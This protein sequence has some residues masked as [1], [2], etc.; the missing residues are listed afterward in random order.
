MAKLK[1]GPMATQ[2]SGSIGSTTFSHNRGG[3]YMRNRAI[4]DTHISI[5]AMQA[6][7]RLGRISG[8]WADLTDPVRSAWTEWARQNPVTDRLGEV[9]PLDG[10]QAFVKC[11]TRL[12]QMGVSPLPANPPAIMAPIPVIAGQLI[13]D[14]GTSGVSIAFTPTPTGANMSSPRWK[15]ATLILSASSGFG[16]FVPGLTT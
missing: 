2:I 3:A 7:D 14:I 15:Q 5:P 1:L 9:R 16:S 12:D 10:H 13:Y 6:K 4:A 11:M 8:K